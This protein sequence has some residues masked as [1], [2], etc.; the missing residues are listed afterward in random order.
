MLFL[1]CGLGAE[2]RLSHA[3]RRLE[4]VVRRE[5]QWANV[6]LDSVLLLVVRRIAGGVHAVLARRG[7]EKL[8]GIREEKGVVDETLNVQAFW[9]LRRNRG[10][11]KYRQRETEKERANLVGASSHLVENVGAVLRWYGCSS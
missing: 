2:E 1:R 8:R 3:R 9:W 5:V 4:V 10:D 6:I 11:E 7:G